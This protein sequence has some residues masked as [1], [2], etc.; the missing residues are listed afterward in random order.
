M[1]PV[2]GVLPAVVMVHAPCFTR[3]TEKFF[4]IPIAKTEFLSYNGEQ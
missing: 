1:K 2:L 3:I 4:I